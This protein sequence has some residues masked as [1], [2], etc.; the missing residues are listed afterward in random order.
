MS[1]ISNQLIK[2][3]YDYVLQSDLSTGIVYRIGGGIPVN[4]TFLSG[5]TINSTFTFADGSEQNGYVLTCDAS[6]NATWQSVSGN[7]SSTGEYLPLSGGTVS[8]GT[9]FQSG[10]TAT[11]ISASTYQNLPNTLYTG[12]GTLSGNRIVNIGSNTLNFSSSTQPNTLVMSGGN[13]GIDVLAPTNPLHISAATNP[14]RIQG[15]VSAGDTTILTVNGQGVVRTIQS[16]T[17]TSSVPTIY[18]SD[19]TVSGP[20]TVNL[21]GNTLN[22]NGGNVGIGTTPGHKFDVL[23]SMRV[24]SDIHHNE[25][26]FK[27]IS[28]SVGGSSTLS[29]FEVDGTKYSSI[30]LSYQIELQNDNDGTKICS[31]A[32]KIK[33]SLS[34]S[35]NKVYFTENTTTQNINT[36]YNISTEGVRFNFIYS[37]GL[38]VCEVINSTNYTASIR[39]EYLN[40]KVT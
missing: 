12:N 29:L 18:N 16:S 38:I 39:G 28:N 9:I 35:N 31:R 8:G 40:I 20:R 7:T 10:L 22:F 24:S 26:L 5:L 34:F 32:G 27:T 2:D 4:P 6:G 3:S 33:A 11:T 37:G 25:N 23:G 17:I 21:N 13:V 1:D 19:G 30:F 14:L 36:S 15:L